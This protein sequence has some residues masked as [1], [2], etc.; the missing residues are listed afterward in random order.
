MNRPP[1][2]TF[3][4]AAGTVTGSRF[5]VDTPGQRVLVD[6]GQ[7][8]G[9]KA[10]RELNWSGVGVGPTSIDAVV[11]THAHVDHC[12]MLPALVRDGFRGP[13]FCTP[14]TAE[15]AAIVLP[16]S[17]RLAE[18]EARYAAHKGY[19]KH[20][21]PLPLFTEH[22]AMVALDSLVAIPYGATH[23]RG[24]WGFRFGSAGHILGSA[25]AHL[26]L[27]D[28][29]SSV[30]FTGDL[31]RQAHPLLSPP[32]PRPSA[33]F[34]VTESTYG[35]RDHPAG[36]AAEQLGEVIRR[37]V[38]RG[39]SV[40][41]P[42][43]AVDRTDVVLHH[44]RRLQ[45][46]GALPEVPV[47]LDSPMG[48]AALG[49]YATA[50]EEGAPDV[51]PE[52]VGT[53]PFALDGLRLVR[54]VEESKKLNDDPR[55]MIIV[56]SSGMVTGGRVVHHVANRIDDERNTVV[57]LGYQASG[58]RGRR[59]LE[60]ES[61]LKMLG[62]YWPV[63]A[64]VAHIQTMSVHADRDELVD[65]IASGPDDP[66]MVFAVHGEPDASAALVQLIED[67]LRVPAVAPTMG[68]RVLL[69]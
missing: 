68:E 55:P 3:L 62:R 17:G 36:D 21:P 2:I 63:R 37:T 67:R 4:G 11:L 40:V 7:F 47:Y 52:L 56:S 5:L 34:V 9:P 14:S 30:V 18:E 23:E 39:G 22:D 57:L 69:T 66:D 15:L 13:I 65:W 16:D 28:E 48:A 46:Q 29:R 44:L 60:G 24:D 50:F 12:G 31:G 54:N 32:D 64:E 49:V 41:I 33:R 8:Q 61:K 10:L 43:F 53:H 26:T 20:D 51:R 58:T 25:W 45:I 1:V 19:S 42:A 27:G 59:L 38:D 35:N 6:C